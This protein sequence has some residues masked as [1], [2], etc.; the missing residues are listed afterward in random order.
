MS[1]LN[2]VYNNGAYPVPTI[3][4]LSPATAK[5]GDP[6][7]TLTVNGT[8]FFNGVTV[9]FQDPATL[10]ALSLTPAIVSS[11]QL[12]ATIPA[13]AILFPGTYPVFV[14]SPPPVIQ[15]SNGVNFTVGA[16]VY[17][18]PV[19]NSISPAT[20]ISG[21]ILPVTLYATGTNFDAAA[22]I[23][24]NGTAVQT[25]TSL[26]TSAQA[27][28]PVSALTT[29]GTVQVTISNPSPGGGPS[30]SLSFTITAPNPV[31]TITSLSPNTSPN[32]GSNFVLTVNG[33]NFLQGA[34]LVWNLGNLLSTTFVSATQLTA[35]VPGYLVTAAGSFPV[36]IVDP[37]P[38]GASNAVNFTV[39]GPPPDFSLNYAGPSSLT[40]TAGQTAT[41]SGAVYVF[42]LNGFTGNV[43]LSC[44]SPAA[45]TNCSASPSSVPP[46]QAA[47]FTVTTMARG[48]AP[49][50][51]P[52]GRLHP[53]PQWVRVLLLTL[54]LALV[55]F[56]YTQ[57]RRQRLVGALPLAALAVFVLLQAIGCGGGS[58]GPPPPTGTPA[59]TYTITVT[60]TSGNLTHTTTLTLTVN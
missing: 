1:L 59:G 60:G 50:S 47:T 34:T 42:A 30:N 44:S 51:L 14:I 17:P 35:N 13:S 32:N 15:G 20:A 2:F 43:N 24:F 12:T 8:N 7:F 38:G 53:S 9:Q 11:S 31:P 10:S 40:V 18:V 56:R 57:T 19:L 39:T 46:Q 4:S 45:A 28:I 23:N 29:P 22:V 21:G 6:G 55:F 26:H 49:P 33:T 48:I 25:S 41:F 5:S 36:N 58:S 52:T 3:T 37:A 27:S 54:L 16:G